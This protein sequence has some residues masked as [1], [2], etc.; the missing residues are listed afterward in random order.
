MASAEDLN[1]NQATKY[2]GKTPRSV[3]KDG[4][5]AKAKGSPDG[6]RVSFEIPIKLD[7][8]LTPGQSP[9]AYLTPETSPKNQ[10]APTL[11][12]PPVPKRKKV[13][14]IVYFFDAYKN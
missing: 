6:K 7:A 4:S 14:E 3:L 2:N 8:P 11:K 12:T 9:D 13:P 10:A 5:P 1:L